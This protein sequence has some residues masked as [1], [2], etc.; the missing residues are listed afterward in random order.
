[1][2]STVLLLLYVIH[3]DLY[4]CRLSVPH[5]QLL[6]IAKI[7]LLQLENCTYRLTLFSAEKIC[8]YNTVH[9]LF[10]ILDIHVFVNGEIYTRH[11][12]N[13]FCTD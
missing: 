5:V 6:I 4:D 3:V 12:F 8:V 10:D 2:P 11:V 7:D 1:M 9:E 13:P